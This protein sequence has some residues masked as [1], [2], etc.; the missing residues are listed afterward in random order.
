V[1]YNNGVKFWR[2]SE[3]FAR[4]CSRM[5]CWTQLVLAFWR[6]KLSLV[7]AGVRTPDR[8]AIILVAIPTLLGQ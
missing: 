1:K 7:P 6:I 5:L 2:G 8:P 3:A 4:P